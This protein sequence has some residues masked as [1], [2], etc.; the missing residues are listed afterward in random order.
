M[1]A[2]AGFRCDQCATFFTESGKEKLFQSWCNPEKY[3]GGRY[4][5]RCEVRVT[6]LI[7]RIADQIRE[8]REREHVESAREN[9]QLELELSRQRTEQTREEQNL[10]DRRL[11]LVN[12]VKSA[13]ESRYEAVKLA[14][15]LPSIERTSITS[16]VTSDALPQ[17]DED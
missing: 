13:P 16:S 6:R 12:A 14:L 1:S 4:C 5:N 9:L 11:Q 2:V 7:G 10:V 3:P 15:H 8:Q 17:G